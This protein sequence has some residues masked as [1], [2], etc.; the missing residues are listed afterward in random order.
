LNNV[1]AMA[2]WI[3]AAVLI[4]LGAV[5]WSRFG[6]AT[7]MNAH[8]FVPSTS[9]KDVIF[10]STIAFAFGGVESGSTMG[11]EIQDARRT[12]PRAVLTAGAVMTLLYIAGTWSVL[13]ALPRTQ[14]SGLDGIMQAIE[15]ITSKLGLTWLVPIAAVFVTTNALGG[16]GGWFAAT[17]RLPFVAGIDRYLPPAFGELHPRW[18]TPYVA[19]LVQAGIAA[20]FIFLGQA[21]TSVRGA[22]QVLVSMGIIAY[23]IPFLFMFAA[24]VV[25]QREPTGPDVMRVP[26]GKPVAIPLASIGFIVTAVSIVLACIPPDVEPNKTLAVVKVV[27]LSLVLIGIGAIVYLLGRRRAMAAA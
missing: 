12:I 27:G 16:V 7:P 23:F 18:H 22:Y 14:I 5:S 19:L 6:S 3:P 10:W 17:A 1:G 21:G 4:V 13:L 2:S 11:E 26:G 25:L 9:L 8:A 15:A 24:M 20:V